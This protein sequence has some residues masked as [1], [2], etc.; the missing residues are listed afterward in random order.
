MPTVVDHYPSDSEGYTHYVLARPYRGTVTATVTGLTYGYTGPL[1]AN[2]E[3]VW[4]K[5]DPVPTVTATLNDQRDFELAGTVSLLTFDDGTT[6][7]P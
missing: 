7:S 4:H 1:D 2:G 3:P 5:G 6:W